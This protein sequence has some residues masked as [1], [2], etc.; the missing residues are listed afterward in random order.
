MHTCVDENANS[1]RSLTCFPKKSKMRKR[2]TCSYYTHYTSTTACRHHSA[3]INSLYVAF[4]LLSFFFIW[5]SFAYSLLVVSFRFVTFCV[6]FDFFSLA[7]FKQKKRIFLVL[8]LSFW[9]CC[10]FCAS[11]FLSSLNLSNNFAKHPFKVGGKET[12]S[13]NKR[14]NV[15]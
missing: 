6:V 8:V 2:E 11:F 13:N 3:A 15:T 1:V 14:R 4:C 10:F 7:H 9:V 12:I 5:H